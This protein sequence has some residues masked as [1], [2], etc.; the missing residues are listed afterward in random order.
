MKV[1]VSNLIARFFEGK[2]VRHAFGIIGSANA[3]IF[4]SIFYGSKIELIC[5][6]HE[7]ACTM[8]LQTYWKV[9]GQPTFA[10]V[11]AGAGSSNAIT[12]VLSAWADSIPCLILSG[13]ENTRYITPDHKRRLYGIQGYDS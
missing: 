8:A 11:T 10:L 13:Q 5:N 6:H 9:T 12:G 1:K 2:G 4:D 7:Q 3:H